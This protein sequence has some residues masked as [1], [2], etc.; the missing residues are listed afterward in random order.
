MQAKKTAGNFDG[1][2]KQFTD[3]LA[4]A[5]NNLKSKNKELFGGD[6]QKL[7]VSA[8]ILILASRSR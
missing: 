7:Q 6:T 5:A 4:E 8:C 3:K 2:Y 1:V